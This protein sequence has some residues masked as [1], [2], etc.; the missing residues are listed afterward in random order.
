[1]DTPTG[2]ISS[3]KLIVSDFD[4][5]QRHLYCQRN[6]DGEW[7]NLCNVFYFWFRWFTWFYCNEII[8]RWLFVIRFFRQFIY[9]LF[10]AF[11]LPEKCYKLCLGS[12]VCIITRIK[13][14]VHFYFV[15]ENYRT[16]L[17]YYFVLIICA[18]HHKFL[19]CFA[20]WVVE[21]DVRIT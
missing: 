8:L 12:F 10:F 6:C 9:W 3:V 21:V 7:V 19:K 15:R 16:A 14:F 17:Y 13:D 1:M 18:C 2:Y 4:F 11:I 20:S 5:R